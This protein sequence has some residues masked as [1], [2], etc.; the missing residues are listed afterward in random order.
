VWILRMS[1]RALPIHLHY[2]RHLDVNAS[3]DALAYY[4][5]WVAVTVIITRQHFSLDEFDTLDI[6]HDL[7]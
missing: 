5:R 6:V 4:V 3:G 1:R 2:H 7:L